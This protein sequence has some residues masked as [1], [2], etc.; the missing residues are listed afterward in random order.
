MTR[1]FRSN[2]SEI[3][4]SVG[5]A[6]CG[7][8]HDLANLIQTVILRAEVTAATEPV[9][10]A[11]IKR[12]EQ[13]VDD[14]Q[15]GAQLVRS[16]LEYARHALDEVEP[17]DMREVVGDAAGKACELIDVTAPLAMEK[18]PLNVRADRAQLYD[19]LELLMV[20]ISRGAD[21]GATYQIMLTRARPKSDALTW[22]N[23]E[24]WAELKI[25]RTGLGPALELEEG[26][27]G[28]NA[29]AAAFDL[30]AMNLLR[31]R[32]IIR[33]HRGQVRVSEEVEDGR[34]TYTVETFFPIV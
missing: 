14:G 28:K 3:P 9:S 5:Q 27:L 22:M 29:E 15:Y 1:E 4:A 19:L 26:H 32:G 12:M 23:S 2:S 33:Q 16:L 10:A 6:A 24:N 17:F 34:Q 13:I 21:G 31:V 11:C 25:T 7:I 30:T 8:V 20:E 18:E